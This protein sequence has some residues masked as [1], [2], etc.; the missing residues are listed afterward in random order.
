MKIIVHRLTLRKFNALI[1]ESLWNFG[2][3]VY[4]LLLIFHSDTEGD[5]SILLSRRRCYRNIDG[6]RKYMLQALFREN[7][8]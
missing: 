8:I 3:V 4:Y 1:P 7:V 2:A 5:A 6:I